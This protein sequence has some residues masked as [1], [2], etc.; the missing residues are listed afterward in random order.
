MRAGDFSAVPTQLVDPVTRL[1]FAGNQI[2]VSRFDSA[3]LNVLKY[4]P[5]VAGGNGANVQVPRRIGRNDNQI[6][7]KVD[8]Q[9]S[10]N[11]QVSVRYFF[12]HF[13][14]DPTFNEGNLLSYRNPTLGSR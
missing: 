13:T 5:N 10:D 2:P 8:S 3:A 14:N 1:P 4:M 9:L 6:I 11:N 12:D 7:F